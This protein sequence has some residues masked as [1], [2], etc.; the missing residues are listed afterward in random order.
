MKLQ[1]CATFRMPQL[2]RKM[3][4]TVHIMKVAH[5]YTANSVVANTLIA[6]KVPAVQDGSTSPDRWVDWETSLIP[7]DKW[8]KSGQWISLVREHAQLV[9]QD[10]FVD[11]QFKQH[12]RW[13]GKQLLAHHESTRDGEGSCAKAGASSRMHVSPWLRQLGYSWAS[14]MEQNMEIGRRLVSITVHKGWR[15]TRWGE[16]KRERGHFKSHHGTMFNM[17]KIPSVQM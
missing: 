4:N 6:F 12:C 15:R 1:H 17:Q 5:R 3:Q 10:T 11:G 8:R 16:N 14:L 9:V 2:L 7:R 13:E